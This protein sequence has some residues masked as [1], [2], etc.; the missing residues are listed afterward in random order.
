MAVVPASS[1][2]TTFEGGT[3]TRPL[4]ID[5]SDGDPDVTG[6]R[7]ILPSN[8][9]FSV[10]AF[11]FEIDGQFS[12]LEF[13][14]NG[15]VNTDGNNLN[16]GGGAL[17]TSG[18]AVRVTQA[19]GQTVHA[20]EGTSAGFFGASAVAQQALNPGTATPEQIAT[21]LETYGLAS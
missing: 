1:R 13:N 3:I 14:P 6:L 9:D 7:L 19:G 15:D 21:V 10:N 11:T 17:V 5:L 8:F 4:V 20:L 16:T 2:G 18:G 12:L